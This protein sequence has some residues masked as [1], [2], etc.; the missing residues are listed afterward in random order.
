MHES[1]YLTKQRTISFF[2]QARLIQSLGSNVEEILE[3]GVYHSLLPTLLGDG[4]RVT[5]ADIDSQF[6]PDLILDLSS[7]FEL[8]SD[9]F[10]VIAL[11]QVLEHI[12]YDAFERALHRLATATKKFLIIS[13]PYNS[14]YLTFQA[15]ASF[16]KRIRS[17][18]LEIPKFWSQT[19]VS[20]EHYWEIGQKGYPVSRIVNS[21]QDTGMKVTR[22][23]RDPINPYHYFFVLTKP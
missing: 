14:T 12:P 8:P 16:N 18:L 4:Y 10:D 1:N 20:N 2:N 9:R 19:P 22:K 13:L 7:E 6:N 17:L 23:Y 5:S 21:M 3:V 11:F 15:H